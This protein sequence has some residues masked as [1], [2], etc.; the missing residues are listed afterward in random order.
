MRFHWLKP[1]T[2]PPRN[3]RIDATHRWGLP[4]VRCPACGATWG[5]TAVAYPSADLTSLPEQAKYEEPRAEPLEEYERLRERVRAWAPPGAPL[6]PGTRLGLLRGTAQGDFGAFAWPSWEA[7]LVR[8]EE[9]ERLRAEGVR[10]L[11]ACRAELRFRQKNPPELLELEL[12]PRGRLHEQCLPPR[13]PP[14][15]RCGRDGF[16]RPDQPVLDAKSL[17]ED[18]DLFR[19]DNFETMIVGTERFVEAVKRLEISEGVDFSELPVR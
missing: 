17:P 8:R 15:A 16:R 6:R 18:V 10:G 9:L 2:P 3:G 14:C 19:L 13:P 5:D 4:G 11:K 12:W 1:S 7:L